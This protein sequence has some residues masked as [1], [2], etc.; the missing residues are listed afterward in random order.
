MRG[1]LSGR[2][3]VKLAG[4]F[5]VAVA[6]VFQGQAEERAGVRIIGLDGPLQ[7][8]HDFRRIAA[9]R[10]NRGGTLVE[11]LSRLFHRARQTVQHA[12]RFLGLTIVALAS[13]WAKTTSSRL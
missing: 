5:I 4:V 7:Q 9:Q 1:E 13:A 2:A 8:R 11:V 12:E 6:I 3:L 10:G